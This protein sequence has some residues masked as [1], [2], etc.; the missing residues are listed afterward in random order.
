ERLN[1]K[2]KAES[3]VREVCEGSSCAEQTVKASPPRPTQ[4]EGPKSTRPSLWS[5]GR[6]FPY[7]SMQQT[8]FARLT[9]GRGEMLSLSKL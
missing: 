6:H 7:P 4:E 2:A 3:R 8:Q 5:L 1:T 9:K